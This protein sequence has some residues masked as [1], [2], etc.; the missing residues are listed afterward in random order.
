MASDKQKPRKSTD[1]EVEERVT[2]VQKLLLNGYTRPYIAE[3]ALRKWDLALRMTDE[4]IKRATENIKAI[5]Q[6]VREDNLA[7]VTTNL[8]DLFRNCKDRGEYGE[9]RKAIMDIA[10]LRGLDIQVV[11]HFVNERPLESL[12]DEEL[13]KVLVKSDGRH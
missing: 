6:T 11:E 1:A 13:N 9:A 3:M 4:Y 10:K 5:N 12:S 2:E 7:L 8:W